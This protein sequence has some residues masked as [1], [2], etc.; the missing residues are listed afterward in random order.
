MLGEAAKINMGQS[1]DGAQY[2]LNPD[3]AILVQGNADLEDGWVVPRAHTKQITKKAHAGD[4]IFSVRAP[5]GEVGKTQYDVVI[6]RGVAAISGNEFIFQALKR[7]NAFGYWTKLSVGSTFDSINS[8]TLKSVVIAMPEWNEQIEI[9]E[10]LLKI[11]NLISLHRRRWEKL[12]NIKAAL[13]EKMFPCG[14][15]APKIR[16]K[17][18]DNVWERHKLGEIGKAQSG[19]TFPNKEQGG[20]AG[21]PFFKVSDMNNYGNE[22]EMCNA[23]NYVNDL[24]CKKNKWTPITE[25]SVVFAKV[26]AAIMLNRKRLVRQPFLLD[27]NSMAYKFGETWD[28]DFGK[29][30]FERIDLPALVQ[31]GA[32]PSYNADDVENVEIATPCGAEQRRIG[33]LFKLLDNLIILQQRKVEKL[34]NVKTA[35][36][37]KMFV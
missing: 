28:I 13:L 7:M 24:Q 25:I 4:L 27:N 32:L 35:L 33:A 9:G 8:D 10:A 15:A 11:D 34:E 21:I 30:L 3:D 36:L 19:V 1:P 26:G 31:I 6:G 18:F 5:V 22:H 2:T 23:K 16:F 29:T 14:A 20:K 17:G 12:N 37:E